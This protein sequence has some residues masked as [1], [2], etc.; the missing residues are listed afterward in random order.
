MT[1]VLS[2]VRT[3]KKRLAVAINLY[4]LQRLIMNRKTAETVAQWR[5]PT[6]THEQGKCP[7]LKDRANLVNLKPYC[8]DLSGRGAVNQSGQRS[9]I[10]LYHITKLKAAGKTP[11]YIAFKLKPFISVVARIHLLLSNSQSLNLWHFCF[12][13]INNLLPD[14][15]L[16][17]LSLRAN[18]QFAWWSY[19]SILQISTLRLRS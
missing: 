10:N 5:K 15:L 19:L 17:I 18:Y 6:T 7:R 9:N 14:F 1:T 2:S 13:Y 8:S 3:S 4:S 12:Q 11:R 16:N